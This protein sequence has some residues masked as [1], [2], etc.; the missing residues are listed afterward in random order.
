M[1]EENITSE[2][3]EKM[4]EVNESKETWGRYLAL[5]TACIAVLAA[6]TP[7]LS[8]SFAN[9]ALVEKNNAI[10]FQNRASDQ[11]NYYQAKGVKKNLAEIFSSQNTDEKLKKEALRYGNEQV[12]I[13]K[14]AEIYQEEVVTANK[15]SE[16]IFEKHHKE[17][18]GVT[19][20]QIAIALSAMSALL[21]RKSFWFLSILFACSGIFSLFLGLL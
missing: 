21:K 14:Q 9:L 8:G 18:F 4:Q 19:F 2:L 6:I 16:K 7:L 5:S 3:N 17:A 15:N 11:W 13:K 1:E 20:F 10:L 12:V